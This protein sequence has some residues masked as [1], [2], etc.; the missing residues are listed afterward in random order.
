MLRYSFSNG[1]L[2]YDTFDTFDTKSGL[3]DDFMKYFNGKLL[4]TELYLGFNSSIAKATFVKKQERIY[5]WILNT[6]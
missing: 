4:V 6:I 1:H 5:F 3:N 2:I